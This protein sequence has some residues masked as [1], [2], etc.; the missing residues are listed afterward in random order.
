VRCT[1]SYPGELATV[2]IPL[3]KFIR[4]LLSTV[5]L[6]AHSNATA[7]D[8]MHCCLTH[9]WQWSHLRPEQLSPSQCSHQSP[10]GCWHPAQCWQ[11]QLHS[12]LRSVSAQLCRDDEL[13][14]LARH[15]CSSSAE[16]CCYCGDL[17]NQAAVSSGEQQR[18]FKERGW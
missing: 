7:Q 3:H 17:V 12:L 18:S 2:Q 4:V 1:L 10:A 14:W 16:A 9:M 6:P 11:H 5:L 8:I 15:C 13:H